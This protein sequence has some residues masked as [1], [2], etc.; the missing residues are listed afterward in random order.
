[1]PQLEVSSVKSEQD[2]EKI[3]YD[4]IKKEGHLR[5]HYHKVFILTGGPGTG[6]TTLL[7]SGIIATC[8]MLHK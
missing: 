1:M 5:C 6:K 4:A 8:N 3:C 2:L 7:S